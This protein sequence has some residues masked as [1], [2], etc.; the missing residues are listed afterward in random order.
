MGASKSVFQSEGK[1]DTTFKSKWFVKHKKDYGNP[2]KASFYV[3][4][5]FLICFVAL[6]LLG[7]IDYIFMITHIVSHSFFSRLQVLEIAFMSMCFIPFFTV[8]IFIFRIWA[9]DESFKI[10]QEILCIFTVSTVLFLIDSV[11]TGFVYFDEWTKIS[12]KLMVEALIFIWS[13]LIST[14]FVVRYIK[15]QKNKYK[16]RQMPITTKKNTLTFSL[17]G[18]SNA[19]SHELVKERSHDQI[20]GNTTLSQ[21]DDFAE[22]TMMS[23]TI[24][25]RKE[26]DEIPLGYILSNQLGYNAFL[27]H[28]PSELNVENLL[29]LAHVCYFK[30]KF[31]NRIKKRQLIENKKNKK[32]TITEV[33]ND[34]LIR[35]SVNIET[36]QDVVSEH[37]DLE[38]DIDEDDDDDDIIELQSFVTK[39]IDLTPR[40]SM[41]ADIANDAMNIVRTAN[42]SMHSMFSIKTDIATYGGDNAKDSALENVEIDWSPSNCLGIL[43][44]RM[45]HNFERDSDRATLID[46]YAG[47]DD[48]ND[49]SDEQIDDLPLYVMAT[50][51]YRMFIK[52]HSELEVNI[53]AKVRTNLHFYFHQNFADLD[54]SDL[55]YHEYRLFHIFDTSWKEIWNLLILNSYRRFLDTAHYL[56]IRDM[57]EIALSD[58]KPSLYRLIVLDSNYDEYIATMIE[59]HNP[60]KRKKIHKSSALTVG[61]NWRMH[62]YS[63][64]SKS[65]YSSLNI[66]EMHDLKP[67]S[68]VDIGVKTM[69]I[70]EQVH[71]FGKCMTKVKKAKV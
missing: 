56:S 57:L 18:K 6:L 62:G 41:D 14:L 33:D 54:V 1:S 35:Y 37:E 53:S 4:I 44:F 46:S 19:K 68:L 32:V 38:I 5:Y 55:Q 70:D 43:T 34:N 29:F 64:A 17:K 69:P 24:N 25:C 67:T 31:L 11:L 61:T 66:E 65:K 40:H 45:C 21:M 42:D 39:S 63:T 27:Q 2:K 49:E 12:L 28:I 36:A 13:T 52:E 59:S 26:G 58:E 16:K 7:I 47:N 15:K 23:Q 30:K 10:K 8:I 3:G 51:L 22:D 50:N 71:H 48:D 60:Y 9:I 20:N